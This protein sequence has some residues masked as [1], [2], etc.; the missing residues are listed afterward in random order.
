MRKALQFLGFL[1]DG[2]VEWL[3][4]AGQVEEFQVGETLVS[5]GQMLDSVIIL[6]EGRVALIESDSPGH[7][8]HLGPGEVVGEISAKPAPA[9]ATTA[10]PS[11][12]L[13]VSRS[14]LVNKCDADQGF[15]ERFHDVLKTLV[16]RRMQHALV[17]EE[18][19]DAS[20]A[21]VCNKA[22]VEL[23]AE[24]LDQIALAAKKFDRIRAAGY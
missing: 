2:D 10:L 9:T 15:D 20:Q 12:V 7:S 3:L 13:R 17:D 4:S 22:S 14:D 18:E 16:S 23:D 8:R 21:D 11:R 24:M 19:D 5:A 1:T 6:V